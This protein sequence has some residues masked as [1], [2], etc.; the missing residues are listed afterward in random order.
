MYSYAKLK[1]LAFFF[2]VL[3]KYIDRSDYEL[4]EMDTGMWCITN[5]QIIGLWLED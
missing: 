5:S 1:M 4:L 3:D 2:D